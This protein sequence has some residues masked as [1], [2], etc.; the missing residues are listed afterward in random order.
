MENDQEFYSYAQIQ[1]SNSLIKSINEQ[2]MPDCIPVGA[3]WK[4][5]GLTK[6]C[7]ETEDI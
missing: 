2:V 3:I 1:H 7:N 6:M 5:A 4:N